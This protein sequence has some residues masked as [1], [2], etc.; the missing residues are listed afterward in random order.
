M[1]V[2]VPEAR[3]RRV[4]S[5]GDACRRLVAAAIVM[6][7]FYG[8]PSEAEDGA[9]LKNHI[10]GLGT[11]PPWNP[12]SV[13]I[14]RYSVDKVMSSLAPRLDAGPTGNTCLSTRAP[15]LRLSNSRQPNLPTSS[16]LKTGW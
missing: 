15:V 14:C 3:T 8:Q 16:D 4:R 11:C 1:A 6:F 12:Q 7:P 2:S 10:L 13:E 9:S 5:W